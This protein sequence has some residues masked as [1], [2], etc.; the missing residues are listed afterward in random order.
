MVIAFPVFEL[1]I[2]LINSFAD[3]CGFPEV[4]WGSFDRGD[5]GWNGSFI[6]RVVVFSV[7]FDS[8]LKIGFAAFTSEIEVAVIS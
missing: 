8:M 7:D 2:F 4:K 5:A 6:D 3:L 1:L